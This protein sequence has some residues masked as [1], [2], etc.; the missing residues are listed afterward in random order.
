ML[1][2]RS[3]IKSDIPYVPSSED[4]L[5]VMMEIADVRPGIKTIDLGSGDGR[6]VMAMAR[7]GAIA[8]GVESDEGRVKLSREKIEKSG[9]GHRAFIHHQSFWDVTLH[10]YDIITVYGVTSIMERLGKKIRNE[11]KSGCRVISNAF[12]FPNWQHLIKEGEI[13]YYSI[14]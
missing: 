4:R 8:H 2:D 3:I 13:Y 9:L 5:R 14:T 7:R 12:S 11:A 6:I 1:Y 10:T